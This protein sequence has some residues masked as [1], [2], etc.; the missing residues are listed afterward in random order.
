MWSK[1]DRLCEIRGARKIHT[2][3]SGRPAK[4][5]HMKK[6]TP[7]QNQ[8]NTVEVDFSFDEENRAVDRDWCGVQLVMAASEIPFLRLF[9]V[10]TA[11]VRRCVR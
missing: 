3:K 8:S 6:P 5:Y 4:Q 10:Q 11:M 9:Q 1:I 2:E 7:L